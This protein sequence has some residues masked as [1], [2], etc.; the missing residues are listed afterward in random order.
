MYRLRV[1]MRSS[2]RRKNQCHGPEAGGCLA[3]LRR[4][5]GQ[6]GRMIEFMYSLGSQRVDLSVCAMHAGKPLESFE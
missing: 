1:S 3:Y 5:G 2:S 4:R 6:C